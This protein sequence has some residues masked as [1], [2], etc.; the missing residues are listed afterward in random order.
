MDSEKA[1]EYQCE[2]KYEEKMKKI[3]T[4]HMNRKNEVC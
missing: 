1:K 4:N 2:R 3:Y